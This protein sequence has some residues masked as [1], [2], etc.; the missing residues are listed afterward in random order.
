M[1]EKGAKGEGAEEIIKAFVKIPKTQ[2]EILGIMDEAWFR[3]EFG[4]ED[5]FF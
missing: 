2:Q 3:K 5:V 1:C 4:E